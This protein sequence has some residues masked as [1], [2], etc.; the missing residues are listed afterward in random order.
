MTASHRQT[1]FSRGASRAGAALGALLVAAVAQAAAPAPDRE[2]ESVGSSPGGSTDEPV[3]FARDVQ[4]ILSNRCFV[5][6]GPDAGTRKA[7]LRLDLREN[8]VADRGIYRVIAPGDV[9]NSELIARVRGGEG[10]DVMPPTDHGV[11]LTADEVDVLE[12]WIAQGAAYESHW[13]YAAPVRP[14]I[15]PVAIEDPVRNAI[16]ALVGAKL[17]TTD[18]E[19]RPEADRATLVR[20]LCLTLWG[21]PAPLDL[22]ERVLAD[23]RDD[24]YER[25]VDELLEHPRHAEH[26]ARQWLDAAR[27]GDTHG[28]HL[29][30]HRSIWPYR[31]WVIEAFANN[32]PYDQFVVEQLA[33]DLLED[34]SR[35]QLVATGFNRC[36]PT[37]AEGGLI[38]A[39]YLAKYAWD[40]VDTTAT[41]FLGLT[42]SCAKCHDHKYDPFSM[43]EYYALYSFF[44]DVEGEASDGN[45]ATPAPTLPVPSAEL[46]SDVKRRREAVGMLEQE[47]AAPNRT[48]DREQR[49]WEQEQRTGLTEL[50]QPLVI[51]APTAE[52]T[53]AE[54]P[55]RLTP[56]ADG[57]LEASGP[58]AE[59]GSYTLPFEWGTD[60]PAAD[61][62]RA[63]RLEV[64]PG[65]E[66]DKVGR[67]EHGNIAISTARLERFDGTIWNTVEL[68]LTESDFEQPDYGAAGL[69]DDDPRSAWALAGAVD[70]RHAVRLRLADAAPPGA[71]RLVLEM[72]SDHARHFP[73]AVRLSGTSSIALHPLALGT[74]LATPTLSAADG[75]H[76]F[77]VDLGPDPGGAPTAISFEPLELADGARADFTGENAA[78]YLRRTLTAREDVHLR[79]AFGSDDGLRVWL[80]GVEVLARDVARS[81][82]PRQDEIDLY[83]GGG[84]HE[85]L[86]KVV[87]RSGGFAFG[88][89]VLEVRGALPPASIAIVLEA[90]PA[91]LEDSALAALRDHYRASVSS[92][93]GERRTLLTR[94][95][96]RLTEV[97]ASIPHTLILRDRAEPVVTRILVRGQY[98]QPGGTV[99][100]DVPTL[101]GNLPDGA[102]RNRLGLAQWIASEANPLTARVAVNRVWQQHF[103]RGL[104]TTPDDF[105][106]QGAWPTHP[107]LLDWLACEFMDHEW[108][109]RWLHRTILVSS[110]WRQRSDTLPE[111]WAADPQNEWLARG[112][113]FRLDAEVLRD[114]A[115]FA[116]GL[117]VEM[118]GG[119]SVKPYQPPGL[120]REVAYPS[121]DTADFVRGEGEDLYRRSLYTYWKRTAAPPAMALLDA[122]SREFCVVLRERTNTPL[123]ALALL[124]D[125]QHVEAARA[126]ASRAF[127]EVGIE[128]GADLSSERAIERIVR[129][130][131]A[132][133]PEPF[134]SDAFAA[135]FEAARE[136]FAAD[137]GAAEALL[138][139]GAAPAPMASDEDTLKLAALT[140]VAQTVLNMD[141]TLNLE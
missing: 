16:D 111:H 66:H 34:P 58:H 70:T 19:S 136:S 114:Q 15:S 93:W 117:L 138:G 110:T 104:V 115:L 47:L 83:V 40:R 38:D 94:L 2:Q 42:L 64:L 90:P 101:F 120:W 51:T 71:F 5:C 77:D 97:E 12:R 80:D 69:L 86:C 109:L 132:R 127:T 88:M 126:L 79:L 1:P 14:E 118:V 102:P 50:W 4:P 130:C 28:L 39:E 8:V 18:L 48:W 62:L 41:V 78:V 137:P 49:T 116:S 63:L 125:E 100:S 113:R 122:P 139:T 129:L 134:E 92:E 17:A 87:N 11:P 96:R 81:Y 98:D 61:A 85:L 30:N 44:D 131:L 106:V 3:R 60:G 56:R 32:L 24:W 140:L 121:S 26:M 6:H 107:E 57:A 72:R 91:E 119:P 74:W 68:D 36:N 67:A 75:A 54:D 20:R 55:V 133:G 27:Y 23:G 84:E 13:A 31:D 35:S 105:G 43:E 112:P 73:S 141:S 37:T 128:V 99:V 29:D 33:G 59:F 25:L 103:G 53:R 45:E 7:E 65:G 52:P 76:P 22:V 21:L 135:L 46:E 9:E 89:E 95:E 123:Q 124:N 108:D 10:V 82:A